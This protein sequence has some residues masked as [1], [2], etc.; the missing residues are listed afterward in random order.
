MK[1]IVKCLLI[2]S[3]LLF[4]V[5][6]FS[7]KVYGTSSSY[8]DDDADTGE[9][10]FEIGGAIAMELFVSIHMNCFVLY[11]LASI[12]YKKSP[13][14]GTIVLNII[15]AAFLLYFDFFVTPSVAIFDFLAVFVGAFIIVPIAA[16]INYKFDVGEKI[17]NYQQEKED[18][19][20]LSFRVTL[21]KKDDGL[22]SVEEDENYGE[23]DDPIKN[24]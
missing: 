19:R 18:D 10:V 2:I 20:S 22:N 12:F 11:P 1:K 4:I 17:E 9:E 3:I 7:F 13:I 16:L 24:L 21:N 15:R 5:Y 6:A 23:E 8:Y 14:K